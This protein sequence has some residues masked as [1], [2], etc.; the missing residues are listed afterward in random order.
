MELFA[1]FLS[2]HSDGGMCISNCALAKDHALSAGNA[3]VWC[4]AALF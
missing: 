3:A 4:I 2:I 1:D